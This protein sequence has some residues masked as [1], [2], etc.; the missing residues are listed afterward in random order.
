LQCCGSGSALILGLLDPDPNWA[1]GSGSRRAN[2]T[3]KSE[4]ISCFEIRMSVRREEDF[5]FSLDFFSGVL[6]ITKLQFLINNLF[7]YIFFYKFWSSKPWIR[8]HALT[9]NVR[10]GSE[11]PIYHGSRIR[12]FFH[13]SSGSRGQNSTGSQIRI[14]HTGK[15]KSRI[16]ICI[17]GHMRCYDFVCR[18]ITSIAYSFKLLLNIRKSIT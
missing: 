4:E 10:S 1:C 13:S 15:I 14:R 5:S 11:I 16:R 6:N 17:T 12:I 7:S 3:R 9:K 2:I 18:T 8:I